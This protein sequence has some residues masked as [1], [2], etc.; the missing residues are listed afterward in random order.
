MVACAFH[1]SWFEMAEMFGMPIPLTVCTLGDVTCVPRRFEAD[2][3]LSQI[4]HLKYFLV[5]TLKME[6]AIVPRMSGI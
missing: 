4:F 2:F 6:T 3:A 1:A 5:V